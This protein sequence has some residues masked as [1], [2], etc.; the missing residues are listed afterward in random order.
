MSF[1]QN[2]LTD[3]TKK[4]QYLLKLRII[5]RI[6]EFFDKKGLLEIEAPILNDALIPESYLD[7]F[8][9]EERRVGLDGLHKKEKYMMTSPEAFQKKLMVAG[10]GSN[11][12]ITNSFRNGEPLS[13]KHLSEFSLLEW[14]EKGSN[15]LN[16]MDTTEQLIVY[17]AESLFGKGKLTIDYQGLKIDLTPPWTRLSINDLIKQFLSIDLEETWNTERNEFDVKQLSKLVAERELPISTSSTTTWEQLYNQ[18]LSIY[19]EP[20][21]PTD[22]PVILYD[23]P[24]ELSPIAKPKDG[25]KVKGTVW[26]ERFEVMAAGLELCDTY[27]ENTDASIQEKAFQKEITKIE[28]GSSTKKSYAYDWD[29][30]EAL[31]HGLPASSGN[32]LGID[33]LTMLLGNY[34]TVQEL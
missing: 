21:L 3:P 8:S 18:L 4:E 28:Q 24:Y 20:K 7:I 16:V 17:I 23:Y 30:V 11:F 26:A 12:C 29:F 33:R 25:V 10:I 27:T 22:K 6:R 32:A 13:G 15:Y 14:Y 34:P 1:W 19:I 9:T 31:R 5:S 2:F